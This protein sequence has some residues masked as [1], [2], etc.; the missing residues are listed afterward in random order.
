M[1]RERD[2]ASAISAA[3]SFVLMLRRTILRTCFFSC[4][5]SAS[6]SRQF[7]YSVA[8]DGIN[9]EFAFFRCGSRWPCE[10][11]TDLIVRA[12]PEHDARREAARE[13][14]TDG[15]RW[16][17]HGEGISQFPRAVAEK[18]FSS[19]DRAHEEGRAIPPSS[20]AAG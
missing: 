14:P 15:G 5:R 13:P 4:A 20:A 8:C 2:A 12:R 16:T 1:G 17:P 11:V 7:M 9:D 19:D 6:F 10:F 18:D 3:S